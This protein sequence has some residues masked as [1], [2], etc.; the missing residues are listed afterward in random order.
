MF[1]SKAVKSRVSP[2]KPYTWKI[3]GSLIAGIVVGVMSYFLVLPYIR[4]RLPSNASG[5]SNAIELGE[6]GTSK[7]TKKDE[8]TTAGGDAGD[9]GGSTDK[10]DS[11]STANEAGAVVKKPTTATPAGD[12]ESSELM[13]AQEAFKY[14]LVFIACLECFAHGSND[15]ANATGPFTAVYTIYRD[16]LYE[17]SMPDTPLWIMAVGGFFLSL[18]CYTYGMNVIKTIGSDIT[19]VD[20]HKAFWIELAATFAVIFATVMEFPVST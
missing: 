17:C 9:A 3:L 11:S 1:K 6:A 2:D 4:A 5:N 18:G 10:E 14:V 19:A 7:P 16:G 12:H 15:T 8:T 13:D 20:F